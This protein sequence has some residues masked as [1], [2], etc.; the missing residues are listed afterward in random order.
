MRK[1]ERED[2]KRSAEQ[3]PPS[4]TISTST[5]P[6]QTTL[7]DDAWPTITDNMDNTRQHRNMNRPSVARTVQSNRK[8][9]SSQVDIDEDCQKST[10]RDD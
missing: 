2:K 10:E 8:S 7:D 1:D 3:D 4:G 6:G 9:I 5:A